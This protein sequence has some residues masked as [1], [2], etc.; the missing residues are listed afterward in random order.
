MGDDQGSLLEL[1]QGHHVWRTGE[2]ICNF[3]EAKQSYEVCFIGERNSAMIE[4]IPDNLL[5]ISVPSGINSHKP[6]LND[7]LNSVIDTRF[8]AWD[9]VKKMEIFGRNFQ[10]DWRTIR[11]LPCLMN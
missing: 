2:L 8:P 6:P 11:N 10:P 5:M 9:K 3:S 4:D 1:D 7:L